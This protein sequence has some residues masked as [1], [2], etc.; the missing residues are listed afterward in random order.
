MR[1]HVHYVPLKP[2]A[3]ALGADRAMQGHRERRV[4]SPED[5]ADDQE[6]VNDGTTGWCTSTCTDASKEILGYPVKT[7]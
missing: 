6:E 5:A 7:P 4:E 3:L 2:E 1:Y